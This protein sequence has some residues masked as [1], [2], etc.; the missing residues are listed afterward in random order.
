MLL[1]EV[2]LMVRD[3]NII[4]QFSVRLAKSKGKEKELYSSF[5]TKK[6]FKK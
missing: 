6:Y 3:T 5:L 2:K 1:Q 4:F